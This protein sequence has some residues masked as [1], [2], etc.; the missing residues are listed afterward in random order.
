MDR[1]LRAL[2]MLAL[3]WSGPVAA[4]HARGRLPLESFS[5]AQGLASDS[6]M[7]I[8]TDSRGF[9]WLATLDGLSRYDGTRFVSYSNENGIPDRMIW[10]LAEDGRGA[11]WLGTS[12]GT[13]VMT[14][15]A[16]RGRTLFTP[17]RMRSGARVE[18]IALFCDRRG[19]VWASCDKDLCRASGSFF[20]I[21]ESFRRAGGSH[22]Q[23]IL[24]SP[25]GELWVGTG[26]G[27]MRRLRN[28][29][30]RKSAVQPVG[31]ED[32]V[33]GL[34]FDEDGRLWIA[35]GYGVHVYA[36]ADDD[37]DP[38][39]FHER[40]GKPLLPGTAP[41]YLRPGEAAMFTTT[42]SAPIIC[43]K[44]M[45]ARD[46]T[47]WQPC[48]A[49]LFRIRKDR[50]DFLDG[51]A[52]LPLD[53]TSVAEEPSGDIWIGSRV[54][55]AYRLARSGPTTFT[56]AHGLANEQIMSLVELEDGTV[57]ATNRGGIS[58]F[59]SGTV[60]HGSLWPRG[61]RYRGWGSNQIAVHD[62][63]G[64]WWFASGEGLVHWPRVAR[65][66]DLAHTHPLAIYTMRDGLDGNEVFRL[67][68]DSRGS[69]WAGTFGK[70]PLSRF[71]RARGRFT[72]FG[73]EEG[74]TDAAPTAFAEDRAGNS[75]IGFYDGGLRRITGDRF[76]AISR[77][78]IPPGRV[79]DLEVDSG[80]RLWVGTTGGVARI[81]NPTA[82]AHALAV[83]RYSRA[84]GLASDSGYCI[85]EMPDGRM[86]IGAQR[87]VDI[88][89]PTN[90]RV[91]H[92]TVR[93]GLPSNEVTVALV[94]R[95]G[96]L[97]LG[98][99]NG[100]SVLDAIPEPRSAPPPQPRIDAISI[101]GLAKP[102]AELGSTNIADVRV[103]YPAHAMTVGFSAPHYDPGQPLR[104]DYRLNGGRWT[105]AGQQRSIVFDRLPFGKGTVEVRAVTAN[106]TISAPAQVSFVAVPPIWKRTWF[107]LL[108]LFT[109]FALGL[110]VHRARV[111][112][113]VALE[114]VRTR[115]ATDLHDDLGS[116]L[117]RI[118]ILSEVAKQK[119]GKAAPILDEI[120]ESARGLID[121]LGDS[122]WA[123]DPRRD[124]VRSV[125]LRAR[126]FAAAVFEVQS[127]AIDVD[128]PAGVA[129]L[130]LGPE[131][132]RETY[133]ILKEALNNAA[134]HAGARN[135]AIVASAEGRMLHI[136]VK[137]DG[138]G[139][140]LRGGERSDGGRGVPNMMERARR[141]GGTLHIANAP[142]EGTS[143]GVAIPI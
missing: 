92:V 43:R 18:A 85:V 36:P 6:V 28:G 79:R 15:T 87:G 107:L 17:V 14:P 106:G 29:T 66:E 93:D 11:I 63:D 16:T 44:S 33:S 100:L 2:L 42:S 46:G 20:E 41:P 59:R 21:D 101:D 52:G 128:V 62:R 61:A 135:V 75:W 40:A 133:L 122:I 91:V 7:S 120:A 45:R 104:F 126:D 78:L 10:S 60:H 132:R 142:G 47:I 67:W 119:D 138:K 141:L 117:S 12:E 69:L 1:L 53:I 134:R 140:Q 129:S 125:L 24:E 5:A 72:S 4:Q 124:D 94:D 88:L 80:G 97:W 50:V 54:A 51:D 127:I 30:W 105:D 90:G 98:T 89:D 139:F 74:F 81:D 8:L 3:T 34:V 115:V 109:L 37:R 64:T 114:R 99:V 25:S 116:S 96:R 102:V 55:G 83:R 31:R 57:C 56:S 103:A 121:A 112:H 76:E 108:A 32:T 49:G 26:T 84:N 137:D 86:A 143:V 110:L 58:C 77:S 13:V 123:I 95:G 73:N 111:A 38:R 19:T 131:Q 65:I 35:N 136:A 68:Q 9:V 23:V 22:V 82:A 113:V 27:L 70:K 48:S 71:N 39:T 130:H 118:S